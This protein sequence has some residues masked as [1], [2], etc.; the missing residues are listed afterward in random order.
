MEIKEKYRIL[1]KLSMPVMI[2]YLA[3][4]L[5]GFTDILMVGQLGKDAITSVGLALTFFNNVDFPKLAAPKLYVKLT[6]ASN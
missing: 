6:N 3:Y 2:S 1:T 5:L 4:Q